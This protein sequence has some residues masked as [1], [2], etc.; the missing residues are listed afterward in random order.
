[1]FLLL[2][3]LIFIYSRTRP[4]IVEVD[5]QGI[6][7]TP[8]NKIS[9]KNNIINKCLLKVCCFFFFLR[10]TIITTTTTTTTV[11]VLSKSKLYLG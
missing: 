4:F 6:I 11:H 2:L 1:M 9:I 7:L 3:L 5:K 8:E 10:R